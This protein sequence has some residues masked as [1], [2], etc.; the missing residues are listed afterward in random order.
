MRRPLLA[1]AAVVAAVAIAAVLPGAAAGGGGIG[2]PQ[3]GYGPHVQEARAVTAC[4]TQASPVSRYRTCL[5]NSLLQLVERTDDPADELPKIDAY[6]HTTNGWL[7]NNCHILMHTVGRKFAAAA[8]VTLENLLNYLPKTND[9]GC[10]AGF[11]H[12][13]LITLGPQIQKLG[14]KG[15]AAECAKATT[16]YERYSCV[17]GLGHAYAR[18][19]LDFPLPSV[20][21]CK[22]LGPEDAVDCAQGV[23]HDYWIAVDGLDNTKQHSDMTTSP[24]AL[25]GQYRGDF[26]R[27]C[28]YRAFLERPPAKPV[29][30]VASILALCRGLSGVQHK[31][32]VTGASVIR[33]SDPFEQMATCA[34]MP[35]SLA[36]ACAR[37]VRVPGVALSPRATRLGLISACAAFAQPAQD[38]CYWW[39][40]KALNVVTN[41]AFGARNCPKLGSASARR[42]CA[43]GAAAYEGP[44]VTFS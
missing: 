44:L 5:E 21:S 41:G 35:A 42:S 34:A 14:P 23:F 9:P 4:V 27:A 2:G 22:L 1:A 43:T 24:R 11:A 13:M 8:H 33:S 31:G 3:F 37:G 28:W 25:C 40:G 7:A 19:Y 32:C 29:T 18:I 16:R 12:G 39:L 20:A 38:G 10:S 30:S 6:V 15:A 17:H 26:A 36:V